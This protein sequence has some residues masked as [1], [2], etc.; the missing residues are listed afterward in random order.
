MTSQPNPRPAP[1]P[2]ADARR[3]V[4][5]LVDPRRVRLLTV[6][7]GLGLAQA[8]GL[9]TMVATEPQPLPPTT[10]GALLTIAAAGLSWAVLAAWRV[11]RREVMM[12]PDRVAALTLAVVWSTVATVGGM[13]IALGRDETGAGAAIGIAGATVVAAV[14]MHLM[15]ARSD[16]RGAK[17]RLAE[18]QAAA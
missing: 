5:Q 9:T 4:D 17:A 13:V 11:S 12:L 16:H 15:R 3:L 10:V 1:H 18:L 8:V 2:D 6:A 7:G 14:T